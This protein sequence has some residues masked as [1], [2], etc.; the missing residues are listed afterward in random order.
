[1]W[2]I[3]QVVGSDDEEEVGTRAVRISQIVQGVVC[4]RWFR[5]LYVDHADRESRLFFNRGGNHG[6]AVAH[7]GDVRG[8]SMRRPADGDEKHNIKV[9]DA[10]GLACHH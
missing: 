10:C 6:A 1:L 7:T 2:N 9:E 3:S 8:I 5:P 4:I